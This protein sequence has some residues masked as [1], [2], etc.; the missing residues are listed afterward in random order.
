[1]KVDCIFKANSPRTTEQIEISVNRSTNKYGMYKLEIPSVDG[2]ECARDK[3]VGDS[4]RAT[5]ISS[6]SSACNVPG[7]RTTSDQIAIKSR[8]ANT[9]IYSLGALNYRP[10][11]RSIAL[12]GK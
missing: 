8:Q 6:S 1:M 10:S 2:I 4:C 5:L 9:C 3:A 11:R 7:S 12:C